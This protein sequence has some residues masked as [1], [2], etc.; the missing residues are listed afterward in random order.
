MHAFDCTRAVT[1]W[2]NMNIYHLEVA[3]LLQDVCR[4][5]AL[6]QHVLLDQRFHVLQ[7][8]VGVVIVEAAVS[9]NGVRVL[10]ELLSLL[11]STRILMLITKDVW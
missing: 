7:I 1:P 3:V 6:K 4:R 5:A 2:L 11:S 8:D 9:D 10:E